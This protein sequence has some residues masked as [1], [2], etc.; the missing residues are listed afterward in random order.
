MCDGRGLAGRVR[1]VPCCPAQVSGR[2]VCMAGR[3]ASLGHRD[4][5]THPGAGLL[6]RV[7]RSG[8]LR[9]SRLEAVKDVL[10]ARCCP[11][12]EEVVVRIGEGPTAADR[13]E[14]RVAVFREDHTAH[15]LLASVQ[16]VTHAPRV[17]S[18]QVRARPERTT[19]TS[20]LH[21]GTDRAAPR[22]DRGSRLLG[23][24]PLFPGRFQLAFSGDQRT[25]RPVLRVFAGRIALIQQ[26]YRAVRDSCCCLPY[27]VSAANRYR[28]RPGGLD[29]GREL[30]MSR[31]S[32]HRRS[33]RELR[34][35][36][37][38]ACHLSR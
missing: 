21:P 18:R 4:L 5:A 24:G 23:G 20:A 12:G 14:T 25:D 28:G 34:T 35:K 1:G 6:D 16:H 30:A 26:C 10:R 38:T 22:A 27:S 11:Q 17:A 15:L 8:A 3:R 37:A 19:A 31:T 13:H 36:A 9:P 2:G 7:A 33:R 29:P 32:W